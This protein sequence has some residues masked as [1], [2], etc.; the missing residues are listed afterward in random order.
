MKQKIQKFLSDE[1][2]RRIEETVREAEAS[3]SGEIVV[4]AVGESSNYP[5][6]IM[7][8]SGAI[9]LVLAVG[10]TMLYGSESM[11]VFLMLFALFFIASNEAV[12]RFS[13]LKRPF[14]SHA[15]IA[16]EVEEAA[17]HSF[18]HRK[19]HET[20][21]RTGILIY[22]SLY[23]HSV[24]V[25]ADSGIDAVVGKQVW[26]GVVDTITKGIR[27]G[28]QGEAIRQAVGICGKLLSQHFPRKADDA[29]ELADS[30]IIG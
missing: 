12:K 24:R 28:R 11:W 3:T 4:M 26:Q 23:E 14:V 10:G 21:D 18:Y 1:E 27:D 20:R 19:V 6:A 13:A 22:I 15:E 2:R 17:I 7:A 9:S 5:S 16:E 25:L 29:N 30:V 8:A